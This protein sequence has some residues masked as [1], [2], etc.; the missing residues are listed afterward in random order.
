VPVA[1]T[2]LHNNCHITSRYSVN[3]CFRCVYVIV[4][5]QFEDPNLLSSAGT[6]NRP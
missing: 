6:D 5:P 2:Q 1:V 3:I 4:F